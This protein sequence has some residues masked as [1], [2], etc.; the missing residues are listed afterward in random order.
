MNWKHFAATNP[1]VDYFTDDRQIKELLL[2]Q[3][4]ITDMENPLPEMKTPFRA[5]GMWSN[6]GD[7]FFV[8]HYLNYEKAE[9]NGF[10]MC[11]LELS[12]WK[13][14]E[15]VTLFKVWTDEHSTGDKY[16]SKIVEKKQPAVN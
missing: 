11:V 7:V 13:P 6:K 2:A 10:R 1:G 15:I 4:R 5:H 9:D 12:H 16:F 3:G 14:E 8:T